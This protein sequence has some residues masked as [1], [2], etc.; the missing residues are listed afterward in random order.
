MKLPTVLAQADVPASFPVPRASQA[1]AIPAAQAA[2]SAMEVGSTTAHAA[3]TY[4]AAAAVLRR[5]DAQAE[6]DR[7]FATLVDE[8]TQRDLQLKTQEGGL[9]PDQYPTQLNA[10]LTELHTQATEQMKYPE[11]KAALAHKLATFRREKIVAAQYDALKIKNGQVAIVEGVLQQQDANLAVNARK[12]DG[13]PDVDAR[14]AA[15]ARGMTR[16]E[17]GLREG[18]YSPDQAGAM[19]KGFLRTV[20]QGQIQRDLRD[21]TLRAAVISTLLAGGYDHIDPDDQFRLAKTAQDQS[22]AEAKATWEATEKWWKE[23]QTAKVRELFSQAANKTLTLPQLETDAADWRL[24]REDYNAIRTE[25]TKSHEAPSDEA[26]LRRLDPLV[27]Q[28]VPKITP[29][30]LTQLREAGKLARKDY[31]AYMDKVA[32]RADVLAQRGD[33]LQMQAHNQAEQLGRAELG[34]PTLFDKLDANKEKAWGA[35]LRE[36]TERSNAY[37]GQENPLAVANEILPRYKRLLEQDASLNIQQLQGL[38]GSEYP[39]PQALEA[40][41]KTGQISKGEYLAKKRLF[42]D[43][44]TATQI[45]REQQRLIEERKRTGSKGGGGGTMGRP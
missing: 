2:Q 4:G 8:F 9:D 32:A 7:T 16:G 10:A 35:Y 13:S 28:V 11:A 45:Q 44:D 34:I 19:T 14:Q 43:L 40:A 6:V 31:L 24:T 18:R 17:K 12:P 25:L 30:E 15:F 42:L 36:L 20:Q 39:T 38:I 26:T 1:L 37:G 5:A 22:D 3:N 27:H 41:L 21:P 33:S 23:Q 29:R